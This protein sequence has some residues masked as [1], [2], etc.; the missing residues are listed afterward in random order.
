MIEEFQNLFQLANAYALLVGLLI[1]HCP[2]PKYETLIEVKKQG[3]YI[4]NMSEPF[5]PAYKSIKINSIYLN[6]IYY[7]V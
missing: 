7:A 3:N 1:V 6:F 4:N 2:K 5:L